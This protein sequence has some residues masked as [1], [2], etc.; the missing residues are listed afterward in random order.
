MSKFL[1]NDDKTIAIPPF[2]FPKTAELKI[3]RK[4]EN[5]GHQHFHLSALSFLPYQNLK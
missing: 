4:V 5:A 3:N 1:H 2:F